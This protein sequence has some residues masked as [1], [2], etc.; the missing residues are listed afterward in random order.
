MMSGS[1]SLSVVLGQGEWGDL[2][3]ESWE[4]LPIKTGHIAVTCLWN[5]FT[6]RSQQEK[7]GGF[8][9]QRCFIYS[10]DNSSRPGGKAHT[11]NPGIGSQRG[12]SLRSPDPFLNAHPHA[13]TIL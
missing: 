4:F 5:H 10:Q 6:M 11:G 2:P 1:M 12:Q 7:I 9:V 8:L 3:G 13:T